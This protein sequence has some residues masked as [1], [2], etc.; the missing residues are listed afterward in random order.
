MG[1][2]DCFI[3]RFTGDLAINSG[4]SNVFIKDIIGG[5]SLNTGKRLTLKI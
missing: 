5:V 2:G 4:N 1:K 3:E